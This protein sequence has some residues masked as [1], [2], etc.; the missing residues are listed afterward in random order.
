LNEVSEDV[1]VEVGSVIRS[2]PA[3]GGRAAPGQ[4]VI[5][6]VAIEAPSQPV[7]IP[8]VVGDL[9]GVAL[10]KLQ[11]AKFE[12]L[13]QCVELPFVPIN[14]EVFNQ[15]PPGNSIGEEGDTVAVQYRDTD[16]HLRFVDDLLLTDAAV[17]VTAIGV[18][19]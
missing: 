3:E 14:G 12:V 5:L 4:S 1:D 13:T 19:P 8:D 7:E 10:G 6:V 15:I 17:K 9:I 11:G 2:A 18:G 16:C